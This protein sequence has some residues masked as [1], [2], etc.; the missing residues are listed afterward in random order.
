MSDV[1]ENKNK[2]FFWYFIGTISLGLLLIIGY[3]FYTW[4]HHTS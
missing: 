1:T 3:F 2:F 4:M